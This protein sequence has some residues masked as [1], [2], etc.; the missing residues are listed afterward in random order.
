MTFLFSRLRQRVGGREFLR[1]TRLSCFW[2]RQKWLERREGCV[3]DASARELPHRLNLR[4]RLCLSV[5]SFISLFDELFCDVFSVQMFACMLQ[6]RCIWLR[7]QIWQLFFF[8]L[9]CNLTSRGALPLCL[10]DIV[11][12]FVCTHAILFCQYTIW[13]LRKLDKVLFSLSL[14]CSVFD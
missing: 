6:Q 10:S 1:Q 12:R 9:R 2:E 14:V 11:I 4:I 3:S 7:Q 8:F 13:Q 5:C